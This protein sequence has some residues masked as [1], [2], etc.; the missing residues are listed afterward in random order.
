MIKIVTTSISVTHTLKKKAITKLDTKHQKTNARD[1]P[2]STANYV[3]VQPN[4]PRKVYVK[5]TIRHSICRHNRHVS[6]VFLSHC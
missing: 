6:E 1:H 4:Q 5:F 2:T 3:L